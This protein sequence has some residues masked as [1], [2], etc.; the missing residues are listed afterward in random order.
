MS[1]KEKSCAVLAAAGNEKNL[2]VILLALK[3]ARTSL[4]A[5]GPEIRVMQAHTMVQVKRQAAPVGAGK[6]P[7][8]LVLSAPLKSPESSAAG[9]EA[10]PAGSAAGAAADSVSGGEAAGVSTGGSGWIEDILAIAG[11]NPEMQIVLLTSREVRDHVAYRCNHGNIYVFSLPLRRQTL[12]EVLRILLIM[13]GR[14][15]QKDAE[16][17]RLRAKVNEMSVIA[18]AKCLLIEKERMTEEEA[19][20]ALEKRAMDNSLSKKEAAEEIVRK[21]T[22]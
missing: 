11:R 12:S 14:V 21:Y 8:I 18:R 5:A 4:Q 13:Y 10:S 15:S 17:D 20:H 2:T 3:D 19:H 22:L 16:L 7:G 6:P 9:G 1:R